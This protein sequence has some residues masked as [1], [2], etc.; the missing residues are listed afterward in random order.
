MLCD[1]RQVDARVPFD[2]QLLIAVEPVELLRGKLHTN[3]PDLALPRADQF[4]MIGAGRRDLLRPYVLRHRLLERERRT[5]A[6]LNCTF[7]DK[8]CYGHVFERDSLGFE[9]RD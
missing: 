6:A 2:E 3:G 4:G 9:E 7:V 8:R 1:G 5:N